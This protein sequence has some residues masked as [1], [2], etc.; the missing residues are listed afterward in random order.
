MPQSAEPKES[1]S[2]LTYAP[3][4]APLLAFVA[5]YVDAT[6][7]LA[8]SGFFVA[9]ATGSV[10]VAA[11]AFETGSTDFLKVAAIPVFVLAGV[12]TA[13]MVRRFGD[14][15]D[16]AFATVLMV[17]A[18]LVAALA[19]SAWLQTDALLP[20]LFGL[21]AMGVQ[22]TV[23]R[24]LLGGGSTNVMTTNLTQFSVDLEAVIAGVVSGRPNRSA[25]VSLERYAGVI[26]GFSVGVAAGSVSFRIAGTTGVVLM[27]GV[28]IATSIAVRR[29][30]Q[31][32]RSATV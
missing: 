23:A 31:P 15:R 25:L 32:A 19:L 3:K 14:A 26:V 2:Y 12:A 8:F 24:M 27:V 21:G 28:L 22:S 10:V 16:S 7:F 30:G 1:S 4:V 13:A 5:G 20:A 29:L 11:S 18:V 17:E 6:T 9:Q